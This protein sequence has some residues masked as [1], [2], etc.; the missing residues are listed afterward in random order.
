MIKRIS[1]TDGEMTAIGTGPS[2]VDAPV[3][4][5]G[6]RPFSSPHSEGQMQE[7]RTARDATPH[8][9]RVQ[10]AAGILKRRE[11]WVT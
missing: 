8:D 9:A 6:S 11:D 2:C 7:R 1:D 3:A 10:Q 5:T 4:A